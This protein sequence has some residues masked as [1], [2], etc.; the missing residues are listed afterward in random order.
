MKNC[1]TRSD[2]QSGGKGGGKSGFRL[3]PYIPC[4]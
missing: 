1:P 3:V 2:F 4:R